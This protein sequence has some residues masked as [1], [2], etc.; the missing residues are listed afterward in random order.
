[1]TDAITV[2]NLTKIYSIGFWQKKFHA[3]Q[4]I[5]FCVP[6]G[7]IF[8]FLG[9]N[10]AGKST[11]IKCI[12]GLI[13]PTCGTTQIFGIPAS[14]KYSRQCLGFLPEHPRY[15]EFLTAIEF[16]ELMARFKNV[17]ISENKILEILDMVKLST[18]SDRY[19]GSFSKGMLQRIGIAQ[20]LLGDPKLLILD[21]PLSG[22]DPIGRKMVL[23]LLLLLKQ[24][25]KTIFFSTHILH[26]IERTCDEIA[27][28]AHGKMQFCGSLHD[29]VFAHDESYQLCFENVENCD[30]SQL[31]IYTKF[32]HAAKFHRADRLIIFEVDGYTNAKQII[33][34]MESLKARLFSFHP[35]KNPLED[36]LLQ[37]I[38]HE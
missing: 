17:K 13:S 35:K 1:M 2:N 25:G 28:L 37:H 7:S 34:K 10:G 29:R 27:I 16:L 3:L 15:Y 20:T 33:E 14:S 26:D 36:F 30:E 12:I 22:L 18:V 23:D 21:E 5:S 6:Q 24:E 9:A 8:G 11:A 32:H 31:Q 19:L 38:G 4:E